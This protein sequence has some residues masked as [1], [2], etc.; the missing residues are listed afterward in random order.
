MLFVAE[1][2]EQATHEA[3]AAYHASRF[4]QGVP[5]VDLTCGIGGDLIA[6]AKRG[7]AVGY[8]LDR[9]RAECANHNLVVHGLGAEVLIADG[10]EACAFEYALV[11]PA[12]RIGGRRTLELN[13]FEPNPFELAERLRRSKLA[14]MKLSPMLPDQA[15]ESLSP[16]IEFV[17]YGR[18]CREVLL[19]FGEE[20]Q[21][22]RWAVHVESGLRLF[23][24]PCPAPAASASEYF[25]EADPA[26]IRAHSLGTL[27]QMHGLSPLGDS[28]GY[29]TGPDLISSPWLT[30]FAVVNQPFGSEKEMQRW[31][32]SNG[33]S[34]QSVK[35]RLTGIDPAALLKRM[36]SPG[37]RKIELA[38]YY[39]GKR[40]QYIILKR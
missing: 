22:G 1:A 14:C 7:P 34:L 5:V 13:E 15:L 11:D 37:E 3:V 24:S 28:N 26:A 6:L 16:S 17:S 20:A 29:L 8:E 23:A 35:T 2:L 12:R 4:P 18:E 33:A 38:I 9:E 10:M 19:W 40:L 27:C 30:P 25:Y 36:R 32:K 21:D 39:S 31:L